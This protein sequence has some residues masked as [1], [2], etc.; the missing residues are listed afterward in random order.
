L[1]GQWHGPAGTSPRVD[2]ENLALGVIGGD[3]RFRPLLEAIRGIEA[4]SLSLESLRQLASHRQGRMDRHGLGWAGVLLEHD[5]AIWRPE[6]VAVLSRLT[7]DIDD[8][9]VRQISGFPIVQCH[10]RTND[11]WIDAAQESD[12]TLRVAGILTAL[13]QVPP[14]T[15]LAIEEPELAIHPG[16]LGLVL[17]ALS[18]ASTRGQ[19]ILTTHSPEP[20]DRLDVEALRVVVPSDAGA[21]IAPVGTRQKAIVHDALFTLGELLRGEGLEPDL[22]DRPGASL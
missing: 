22:T 20:V 2:R 10:H 15:L 18:E 14:P 11:R 4:Y 17:D 21:R 6:I 3:F 9:R 8:V 5:E 1:D 12:G 7:G 19:V 16:A 13:S